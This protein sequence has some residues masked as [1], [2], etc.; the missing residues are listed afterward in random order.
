MALEATQAR[1][2]LI[3]M[4]LRTWLEH[5]AKL[6]KPL[7]AT[8]EQSLH[9]LMHKNKETNGILAGLSY[10]EKQ[11]AP[12]VL[13]YGRGAP[14]QGEA[15][16]CPLGSHASSCLK[17]ESSGGQSKPFAESPQQLKYSAILAISAHCLFSFTAYV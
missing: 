7:F 1:S 9:D 14:H 17:Q 13:S 16:P 6:P 3:Q 2:L 8:D 4:Y 10:L 11:N 5:V 12:M 15:P